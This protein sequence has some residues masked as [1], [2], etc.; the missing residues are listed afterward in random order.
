MYRCDE[1]WLGTELDN[2]ADGI[3]DEELVLGQAKRGAGFRHRR[4]LAANGATAA[5]RGRGRY[6]DRST[7][8]NAAA[9]RE[10]S[11]RA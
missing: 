9:L 10:S 1:A 11:V 4:M 6:S 7:S 8:T 5:P 2:D 3:P